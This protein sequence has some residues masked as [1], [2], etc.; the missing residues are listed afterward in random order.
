M[1]VVRAIAATGIVIVPFL[2]A[3][4]GSSSTTE[5]GSGDSSS[6]PA[7]PSAAVIEKSGFGGSDDYLWVTAT[8]RDVPVGQFATVSFNLYGADG[9]L[10]ATETQTEQGVNPGAQIM[11]G[12]QV[13]APKGQ[14]VA[15]IEPT[16]E[17]SNHDPA[18]PAKFKDVVLQVGPVTIGQD[19]FSGQTAE[20]E[21]TNPSAEQIPG[22]RVGVTCFDQQGVIVGGGSD[23]PDVVPA[24]GKVMVSARILATGTPDHCEM[25]AQP[26]D[27]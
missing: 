21:L 2:T 17:V 22:A 24:N 19:T 4:Q 11:V 6:P 25:T 27:M 5:Q 23:Y 26:S 20:A 9:T 14:P 3:C 7:A 15:R 12:T 8:V 16:L 1:R 10:L 18:M 13:S